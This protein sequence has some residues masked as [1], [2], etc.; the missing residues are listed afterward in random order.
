MKKITL[1]SLIFAST[2]M[3]AQNTVTIDGS[4]DFL[5][6]ANVF[7]TPANGG[8]FV[9]GSPWAI[10]DIKSVV[11]VSGNTVTLFPNFNTYGD[12]PTDP[13]WVDQGTGIGNKVFEGNTFNENNTNLVGQQ[14]TF[15]AEVQSFTLD[16][17]YEVKAFI[18]VF[19][20]DFSVLKEE[21]VVLIGTGNF[22]ITYTNVEPEDTTVQ[23]G[24]AVTGINANPADEATLGN[25][26]V[27]P[28]IL[29]TSDFD[30]N[31]IVVYP[32]PTSQNWILNNKNVSSFSVN[33]YDVNGKL[34]SVY[35]NIS[36][37][38]FS[39]DA[40]NLKTGLY[41]ATVITESHS[42]TIKLIKK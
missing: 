31:S 1:L 11:D 42:N 21:S 37:Q 24:F 27:G 32:N 36:T 5:G 17:G 2:F 33:L 25:V 7:E 22:S 15:E 3:V 26:V 28:F 12:N 8:A 16:P 39:I 19:N 10:A 34:I 20:A 9:F 38:N 41:F 40:S 18:K 13:F 29:S 23:Y 4:A 14:L 30:M 6:F 35:E